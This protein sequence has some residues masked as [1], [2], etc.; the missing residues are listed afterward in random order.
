[1]EALRKSLDTI[2]AT[3]RSPR[4]AVARIRR[5]CEKARGGRG[6]SSIV[7][8]GVVDGRSYLRPPAPAL[9]RGALLRFASS[10]CR[11]A[12]VGVFVLAVAASGAD[13]R[14]DGRRLFRVRDAQRSALLPRWHLHR[15]RRDAGRPEAIAAAAKSGPVPSDGSREP[16]VITTAPQSSNSPRWSPDGKTIAFLSTRPA[17]GEPRATRRARRSG[18]CRSTAARRA[19]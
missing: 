3:R 2:S 11:F 19:V 13:A 6:D 15:L 12:L 9:C 17:P 8:V 4:R 18:C 7:V 14:R 16:R 1:M 10:G 5:A